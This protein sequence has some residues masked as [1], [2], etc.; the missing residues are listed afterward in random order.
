MVPESCLMRQCLS[1]LLFNPNIFHSSRFGKVWEALNHP[2][3]CPI[4]CTAEAGVLGGSRGGDWESCV[5]TGVATWWL[6]IMELIMVALERKVAISL[7]CFRVHNPQSAYFG[8][9]DTESEM[10]FQET[11]KGKNIEKK[12]FLSFRLHFEVG[13]Y[14]RSFG[15]IPFWLKCL[16]LMKTNTK[17]WKISL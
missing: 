9:L 8:F 13:D 16:T 4:S 17:Q 11:T 15:I 7:S 2:A 10:N 1:N 12:G 6:G 5:R 14:K 3:W